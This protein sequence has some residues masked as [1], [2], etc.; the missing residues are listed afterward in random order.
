LVGELQPEEAVVGP[1][2][3]LPE[4]EVQARLVGEVA[5]HQG[6]PLL[7]R[8]GE[9]APEAGRGRGARGGE[10]GGTGGAREEGPAGRSR[11]KSRERRQRRHYQKIQI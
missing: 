6:L 5:G 1:G 3:L 9:E 4:E 11:G 7:R 8:V 10:G 2:R